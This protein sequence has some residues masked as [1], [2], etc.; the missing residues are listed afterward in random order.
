MEQRMT[1]LIVGGTIG[2]A[3]GWFVGAVIAE[4]LEQRALAAQVGDLDLFDEVYEDED[5]SEDSDDEEES[6]HIIELK[7]E[8]MSKR[9]KTDYASYFR[10]LGRS[11]IAD[12]VEKYNGDAVKAVDHFHDGPD[13]ELEMVS[14]E[15]DWEEIEDVDS[16]DP[17]VISV[18][19]YADDTE[20]AHVTLLYFEDDV[21]TDGKRNPIDRPEKLL[22]EEALLS[23]GELSNDPDIVYVRNSGKRAMYEVVR[24]NQDFTTKPILKKE[25]H[26]AEEGDA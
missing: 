4:V 10:D 2:A 3:T 24:T 15:D 6:D 23:F 12:L 16:G 26:D 25:K 8:K 22:G 13:P 19:D 5:E 7:R 11:D 9:E 20:H 21:L 18:A 14:E 17:R 1:Y